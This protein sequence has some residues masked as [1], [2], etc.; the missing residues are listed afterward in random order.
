MRLLASRL[1]FLGTLVDGFLIILRSN[2][3]EGSGYSLG[4]VLVTLRT[5]CLRFVGD[6]SL[7]IYRA[8]ASILRPN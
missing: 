4:E 7:T 8:M 1:I 3:G 6:D 5:T 2:E